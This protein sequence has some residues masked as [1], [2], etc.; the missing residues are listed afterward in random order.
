MNPHIVL[1]QVSD[2]S[3]QLIG[4]TAIST[5]VCVCG[6]VLGIVIQQIDQFVECQLVGW[7]DLL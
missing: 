4:T 1:Y 2:L 5:E 7:L 3:T 6:I